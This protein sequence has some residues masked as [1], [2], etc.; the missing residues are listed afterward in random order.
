YLENQGQ[1]RFTASTCAE[2]LSGR[3]LTMDA[4]DLD[5]DGDL[6]IVLGSYIRGPSPVPN[7]YMRNWQKDGPSVLILR[8]HL[9]EPKSR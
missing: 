4:G 3:W 9:R 1:M 6:D 7:V 8:N 5:G 2:S